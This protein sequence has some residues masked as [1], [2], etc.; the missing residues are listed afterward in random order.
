MLQGV[1][2]NVIKASPELLGILHPSITQSLG[3]A[4]FQLHLVSSKVLL[5]VAN[6]LLSFNSSLFTLDTRLGL[7]K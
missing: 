7:F 4:C 2:A 3:E 5:G 1:G 6:V